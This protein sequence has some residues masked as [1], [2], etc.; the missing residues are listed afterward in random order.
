M[1]LALLNVSWERRG[2]AA[3]TSTSTSTNASP[4]LLL[5]FALF[6]AGSGYAQPP[7][8]LQLPAGWIWGSNGYS[9]FDG[10]DQ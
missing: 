7:L 10:D 1:L 5:L 3:L 4:F 6:S 2:A 8:R 9:S